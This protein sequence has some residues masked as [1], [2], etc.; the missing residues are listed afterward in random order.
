M[1]STSAWEQSSFGRCV[2]AARI[3]TRLHH[4]R[5]GMKTLEHFVRHPEC[6]YR[7]VDTLENGVTIRDYKQVIDWQARA[8]PD[9]WMHGKFYKNTRQ[10]SLTERGAVNRIIP[11]AKR[12]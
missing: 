2:A 12:A 11:Q 3:D 7:I 9:W 5:Q 8:N 4:L 6:R 1:D 10:K